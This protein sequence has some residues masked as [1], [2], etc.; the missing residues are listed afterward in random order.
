MKDE[1]LAGER[2]AEMR[3]Q[4]SQ[5]EAERPLLHPTQAI[6]KLGSVVLSCQRAKG[7]RGRDPGVTSGE[8]I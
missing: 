5:E 6:Y 4:Q 1:A 3:P 7:R 8:V 2:E